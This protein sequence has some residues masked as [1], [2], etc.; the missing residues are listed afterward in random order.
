MNTNSSERPFTGLWIDEPDVI[1]H[2]QQRADD[3]KLTE[4]DAKD[5]QF[6]CRN[7]YVVFE[8]AVSNEIVENINSDVNNISRDPEKFIARSKAGYCHPDINDVDSRARI[9]DLHVHSIAA[10]KAFFA[11]KI[12][13]F[14]T[15]IF[16]DSPM[17]FQTLYFRY[18]SQQAIHQDPAYVVIDE[19]MKL[20]AS[21]LALEDVKPG[22]GELI[23]YPGSHLNSDFLFSGEHKHWKGSRDGAEQHRGFW[24]VCIPSLWQ[25]VYP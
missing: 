2:I 15:L 3:G 10:R 13:H 8:S 9:L 12:K 24:R 22:S 6:F 7:G 20:C 23:Y 21:W 19:P 11:P 1:E 25:E 5:L 18:G 17:A 14:L 16:E 4:Q